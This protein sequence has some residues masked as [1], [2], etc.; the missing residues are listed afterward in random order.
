MHQTAYAALRP[1]VMVS[2][3]AAES[4]SGSLSESGSKGR[5][6]GFGH[7]GT[8]PDSDP[9]PDGGGVGPPG[10]TAHGDVRSPG[11]GVWVC[12]LWL[13]AYFDGVLVVARDCVSGV[14]G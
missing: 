13:S 3:R 10:N 1:L 11:T 4:G 12:V 8:D 2:L 14:L 6:M 5:G 9:D 7:M